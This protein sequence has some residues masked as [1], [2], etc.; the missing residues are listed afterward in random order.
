MCR[1][2]P[3]VS[4]WQYGHLLVDADIIEARGEK[5]A[6]KLGWIPHNISH[7]RARRVLNALEVCAGTLPRGPHGFDPKSRH[8]SSMPASE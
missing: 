7:A 8:I 1:L 2:T 5:N 6:G 4:L 3:L